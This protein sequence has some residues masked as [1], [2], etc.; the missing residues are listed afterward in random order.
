VT[1]RVDA[2][3]PPTRATIEIN[4]A[5]GVNVS[6]E[7]GRLIV[8]VDADALDLSLPGAGGGLIEQIRAGD[9]ATTVTVVLGAGAAQPRTATTTAD[10]VARVTI[11]VPSSAPAPP[12][13]SA[14]PPPPTAAPAEGLSV[15]A[16][17]RFSTVVLD[18]G[19]GGADTGVRAQDGLEEKELTL[20]LAR[21]L[22]QRLETRLGVR[23][24][25]T[26][27]DDRALGLDERAALANNSKADLFLSLHA[28][29]ALGPGISGAEV[30]VL[31]LD[32]EGERIRH[33]ASADAVALPVLG[34][35]RRVIEVVPWNLAQA[36]HIDASG[37]LATMLEQELRSRVPMSQ[38]PVQRA[39]MRV[40]TGV[41]MPA[42]LVETAYLTNTQQASQ[43]RGDVFR[44]AVA[45]ALYEAVARFRT[46][47]DETSAP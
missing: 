2:P 18:P 13:T 17:R 11:E 45:D 10:G 35:G 24:I 20:D 42:A 28:N 39:A 43:A 46:Y 34:G 6:S 33:G 29:A 12:E 21:R 26:R 4:P 30:Y 44:N 41:N 38:R 32:Q 40:L 27:D 23:V 16:R 3:G 5:A 31:G 14:V 7:P 25:P 19:H 15:G 1:A 8:R 22:R 37:M 36:A 47:T 9:A